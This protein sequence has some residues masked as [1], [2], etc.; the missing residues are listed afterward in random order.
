MKDD[1]YWLEDGNIV[2]IAS[3]SVAFRVYKGLLARASPVF[4]DM[5]A[6]THPDEGQTVDCAPVVRVS[7]Q[8]QELSYFL[9]TLL[10]PSYE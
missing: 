9:S 5:F 1:K 8:S 6:T 7:E 4:Q 2:I 3:D 10:D